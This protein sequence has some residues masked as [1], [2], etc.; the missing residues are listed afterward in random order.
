MI[1]T[2]CLP[3]A[4][5]ESVPMQAAEVSTLKDLTTDLAGRYKFTASSGGSVD[6]ALVEADISAL[7]R[8]GY[9]I[10]EGRQ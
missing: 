8:D 10:W 7:D 1:T 3:G 6:P 4:I 9:V 2:G 5:P